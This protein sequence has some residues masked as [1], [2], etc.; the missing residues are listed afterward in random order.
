MALTQDLIDLRDVWPLSQSFNLK[1]NDV[2]VVAGCFTGKVMDLL[3]T[4][5]PDIYCYGFDPQQWAI[6]RAMERLTHSHPNGGWTLK[7]Y[8]LWPYDSLIK[9]YDW[10]TDACSIDP[11]TDRGPELGVFRSYEAVMTE[12]C[13]PVID[14]FVMNMEGAEFEL[15]NHLLTINAHKY[16]KQLAIQWHLHGRDPLE[17]DELIN[18][19]SK[20]TH[21]LQLDQ[22]PQWTYHVLI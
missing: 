5:Y 8:G 17:M 13:I 19:L 16:I 14:L 3:L 6:D 7:P 10:E 1:P 2:V 21:N 12:L 20:V 22:R 4:L 11:F 18:A 15:I 9:M